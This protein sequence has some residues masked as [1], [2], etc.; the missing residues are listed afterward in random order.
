[1]C[2]AAMEAYTQAIKVIPAQEADIR[3]RMQ[4]LT[5]LREQVQNGTASSSVVGKAG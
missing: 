4:G 3:S 2:D 5:A 1:M